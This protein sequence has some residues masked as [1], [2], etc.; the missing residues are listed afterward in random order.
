[1]LKMRIRPILMVILLNIM[2]FSLLFFFRQAENYNIFYAMGVICLLNIIVYAVMYI[3]D[4]GDV[5]LFLMVS[6]LI[7]IGMIMLFRLDPESGYN[8]IKWFILGIIVF[9]V[10]YF[11]YRLFSKWDRLTFLY[12]GAAFALYILTL[13]IGYEVNGSKNWIAV[14]K[15]SVQPSEFIKILYCFAIASFFSKKKENTG[16][17]KKL[18]GIKADDIL[19]GGFTYICVGFFILQREWG[20]ALLFFLI[21]FSMMFLYDAPLLLIFSNVCVAALGGYGGYL[22]TSHI[23]IRVSTWL[24]PWADATNRGYQI[25]QSLMAICSGGYFGAGIGNG[26]PYLIPEVHSDFIFSAICE[27][28]GIFMGIAIIMLYFIFSYRGFKT[29]INAE[30]NFDKALTLALVISFTF[31][32]FI[33]VGGVIKLIPLTGITLPFVSYGGSSMISSFIMLGI[34]TAVSAGNRK[35]N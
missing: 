7:S 21:Y 10:S 26:N 3:F 28:M 16:L 30:N 17:L 9:F 35:K 18:A 27:E 14:G 25:I 32:T 6:M 19:I 4:L 20:T 34:L 15:M 8:Q 2:G 23:K 24:D 12:I 31:Q 33:I 1:M 11:A 29:A 5:Y 13:T 22:F